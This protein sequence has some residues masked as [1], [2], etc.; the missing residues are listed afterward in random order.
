MARVHEIHDGEDDLPDLDAIWREAGTRENHPKLPAKSVGKRSSAGAVTRKQR[1]LRPAQVNSVLLPC[2]DAAPS[3]GILQGNDSNDRCAVPPSASACKTARRNVSYSASRTYSRDESPSREDAG[4]SDGLSDFIVSDDASE[5]ELQRPPRSMRGAPV[6]PR[7]RLYQR[8]KRQV[9]E[10]DSDED[11]VAD[12]LTLAQTRD[13]SF[14]ENEKH[15]RK[16]S[17]DNHPNQSPFHGEPSA[18][19]HLCVLGSPD[20]AGGLTRLTTK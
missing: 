1:I 15:P 18:T 2:C 9:I 13:P 3:Q 4:S 17:Y 10:S 11:I 12:F 19:M 14:Q 6:T 5:E 7:R 16:N 8:P 20:I